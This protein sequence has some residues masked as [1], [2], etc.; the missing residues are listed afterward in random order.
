MAFPLLLFHR[1]RF[2]NFCCLFRQWF[3]AAYLLKLFLL[4]QRVHTS[5]DDD[6]LLYLSGMTN[7]SLSL[8]AG[9]CAACMLAYKCLQM[10]WWAAVTVVAIP[11]QKALLMCQYVIS[12]KFSLLALRCSRAL[13]HNLQ[14][15]SDRRLIFASHLATRMVPTIAIISWLLCLQGTRGSFKYFHKNNMLYFAVTW[16]LPST[17]HMQGDWYC[18][19]LP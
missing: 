14:P 12:G 4:P 10:K 9:V 15:T 2:F 8:L 3:S 1:D 7:L 18:L 13:W 16:S 11:S 6:W 5:D 19:A 17:C